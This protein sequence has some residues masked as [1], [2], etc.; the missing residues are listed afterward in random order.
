[1]ADATVVTLIAEKYYAKLWM[2]NGTAPATLDMENLPNG[3]NEN[4]VYFS[5]P[6]AK[7]NISN[8]AF[9]PT[10]PEGPSNVKVF[11]NMPVPITPKQ[12][13]FYIDGSTGNIYIYNEANGNTAAGWKSTST[14]WS[15]GFL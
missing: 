7:C 4:A 12:G 3:F 9:D 5:D 6:V 10:Q 2:G 11:V 15:G 1:M 13:W 14:K 8:P